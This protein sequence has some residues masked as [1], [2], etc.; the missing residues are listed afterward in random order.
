MIR[1]I[2]FYGIKLQL[3]K[4]FHWLVYVINNITNTFLGDGFKQF[5]FSCLRYYSFFRT[6]ISFVFMKFLIKLIYEAWYNFF[7]ISLYMIADTHLKARLSS[8]E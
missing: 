1:N 6:N 2:F 5:F 3:K 7:S 8:G 4:N